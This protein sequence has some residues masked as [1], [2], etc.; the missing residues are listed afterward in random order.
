MNCTH[1]KNSR[2]TKSP[3]YRLNGF[4]SN[5]MFT[6][7]KKEDS[8]TVVHN[9]T[10]SPLISQDQYQQLINI[11]NN[12]SIHSQ[13]SQV[14]QVNSIVIED[15]MNR[16]GIPFSFKHFIANVYKSSSLLKLHNSWIVNF[17]ATDHM[18]SNQPLFSS[19]HKLCQPHS[20]GMPNGHS[21]L[22]S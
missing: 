10:I 16:V 20:V 9:V 7:D 6:T 17:V 5:F 13:P 1:C 22:V 19:L 18:C 3:C 14:N 12:N 11:L 4:P 2:H 8:K 15:F 21:S